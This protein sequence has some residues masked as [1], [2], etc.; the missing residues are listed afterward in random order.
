[1]MHGQKNIK[2]RIPD[3][4]VGAETKLRAGRSGIRIAIWAKHFCCL[5]ETVQSGS[6]AYPGSYS[7][8]TGVPS[9]KKAAM[10]DNL[11]NSM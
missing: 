7:M 1:M 4:L 5:F 6:G 8:G 11:S 10:R 3:S 9:R 2:L